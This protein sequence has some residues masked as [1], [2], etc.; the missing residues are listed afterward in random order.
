MQYLVYQHVNSDK[1]ISKL[2]EKV[3][4]FF[5]INSE[6]AIEIDIG[7]LKYL[8]ELPHLES[9]NNQLP[10]RIIIIPKKY[11]SIPPI[12]TVDN[13]RLIDKIQVNRGKGL[14][15]EYNITYRISYS[16]NIKKEQKDLIRYKFEIIP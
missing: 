3:H 5:I 16:P 10:H 2:I 12:L 13:S 1:F 15:W 7:G 6:G 8:K 9:E 11:L 4:P 14:Q